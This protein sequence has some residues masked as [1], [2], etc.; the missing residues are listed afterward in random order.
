MAISDRAARRLARA[1]ARQTAHEAIARRAIGYVR[2]STEEQASKGHGL[3]IQDGAI[4]AFAESQGFELVDVVTDAGVSGASKPSDRP[5][6][7]QIVERASAGEFSILLVWK[8]DRLARNLRHA[9]NTVHEDLNARDVE[10]RSV[11]E[12]AIDTGSPMGRMIFSIFAGMAEGERE[13]ITLRTKGGRLA[14]ARK[15]GVA[16]G[17]APIGY[18]RREDG[19][20][21]VVADQAR[22]V[23]LIFDLRKDGLKLQDIADRLNAAGLRGRD[24]GLWRPGG[25]CKVL[26]NEKYRGA[27]EYLFTEGDGLVHVHVPG[28]HE[29]IV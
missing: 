5:G 16:C 14:K 23:R 6:F 2:V 18:R 29:A 17:T 4:R 12:A 3:E 24:G 22:T 19:S 7:G 20:L 8:F 28:T 15:G 11:T 26:G 9:I 10:L 13:T 1:K 27:L 21:E 25:I